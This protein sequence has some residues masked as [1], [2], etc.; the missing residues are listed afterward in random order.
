MGNIADIENITKSLND[1]PMFRLSL[2]SK[3]LF[4]SNFLESLCKK[5]VG[6][7]ENTISG[8]KMDNIRTESASGM[9]LFSNAVVFV[10]KQA[11]RDIR[12]IR[13]I[14]NEAEKAEQKEK[15]QVNK[16]DAEIK[17]IEKG[18]SS[19]DAYK[20]SMRKFN[21][22][23]PKNP[24]NKRMFVI[25]NGVKRIGNYFFYRCECLTSVTIPASVNSIGT[26]CFE[27][28]R[29][30]KTIIVP[31]GTKEKFMNMRGM[32]K[33]ASIIVEE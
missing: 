8:I 11:W 20:F 21:P 10:S 12:I 31:R 23:Y 1:N 30:L 26:E 22:L 14:W 15:E 32:K 17:R 29:R 5:I 28:C 25:P 2:G 9:S 18:F 13:K 19:Y 3:E 4:H 6:T 24:N 27:G 7:I 33:Y 16:L